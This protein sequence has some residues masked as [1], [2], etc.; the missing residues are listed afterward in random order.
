[1]RVPNRWPTICAAISTA[2]RS[3]RG[4]SGRARSVKWVRRNPAWTS[5]TAICA[6]SILSVRQLLVVSHVS[7]A[8]DL[9]EQAEIAKD[10]ATKA[11]K[12]AASRFQAM[13]HL[14][15]LAEM[16]QAQQTL[17]RAD[18]DGAMRILTD[19]WQPTRGRWTCA[20]GNGTSSSSERKRAWRSART[21][22]QRPR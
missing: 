12:H 18:Y 5:L 2:S 3:R 6:V 19:H 13:R 21:S 1:M 8:Q 4:A 15:Y 17:R 10:Q 16:R 22:A 20:T 14:F 7:R 9:R 11:K